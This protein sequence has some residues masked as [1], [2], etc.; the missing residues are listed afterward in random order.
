MRLMTLSGLALSSIL[1]VSACGFSPLYGKRSGGSVASLNTIQVGIIE[2]RMG[3]MLRNEL[4]TKLNGGVSPKNAAYHLDVK[5]QQSENKYGADADSFRTRAN[6]IVKATYRLIDREEQE[7]VLNGAAESISSYD[8]LTNKF[9]TRIA[10][11]EA[12]RLAA[13][14]LSDDIR[15]RLAIFMDQKTKGRP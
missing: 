7:T 1:L 2:D 8:I 6:L 12:Q 5:V 11:Q 10:S 14:A 3:Q 9:A 4:V 13:V 15:A